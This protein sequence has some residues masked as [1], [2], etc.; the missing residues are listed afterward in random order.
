MLRFVTGSQIQAAVTDTVLKARRPSRRRIS[1][2]RSKILAIGGNL[3][4]DR[5]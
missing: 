4:I 1:G 2:R 5:Q 3:A